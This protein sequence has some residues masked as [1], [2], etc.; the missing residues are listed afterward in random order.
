MTNDNLQSNN[1][2]V[3]YFENLKEYIV[4]SQASILGLMV[5]VL[6]KKKAKK[7]FHVTILEHD[8]IK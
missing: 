4:I 7:L 3:N 8:L 1:I 2:W 5:V 6:L